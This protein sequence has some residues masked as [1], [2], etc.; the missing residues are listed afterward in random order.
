MKIFLPF[1]LL[2]LLVSP[3]GVAQ[4]AK[5]ITSA[6]LI[7]MQQQ[8]SKLQILDVRTLPE[9][10]GGIIKGS[11]NIDFFKDDFAKKVLKLD[12]KA[13]VVVYCAVGGR[14]AKAAHF[15]LL[16]GYTTVYDLKGGFNQWKA[17]GA[18]I[19]YLKK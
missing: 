10:E 16:N 18:P 19:F 2:L 3:K 14:S 5:L 4:E 8:D 15:L 17:Q 11:T 7:K 9:L 1:I 6:E 12:P 13:P